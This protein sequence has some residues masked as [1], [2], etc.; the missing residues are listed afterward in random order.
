[1]GQGIAGRCAGNSVKA[2][3]P[4]STPCTPGQQIFGAMPYHGGSGSLRFGRV[5][6]VKEVERARRCP[7]RSR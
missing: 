6:L 7:K 5:E 2:R 4:R 1:M 3:A